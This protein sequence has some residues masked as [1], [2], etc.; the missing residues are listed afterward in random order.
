MQD[1]QP[2]LTPEFMRLPD[3]AKFIGMSPGFLRKEA[4]LKRGP[5]RARV[6][7]CLLYPVA[8]LRRYVKERTE[9]G[10]SA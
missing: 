2:V 8:S 10:T 6:G 4:R 9:Q 1:P 7:K 3:A 5:E